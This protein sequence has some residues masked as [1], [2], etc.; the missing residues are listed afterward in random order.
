M[1]ANRYP[2]GKV[3]ADVHIPDVHML[4]SV[5]GSVHID[6]HVKSANPEVRNP[7]NTM[8]PSQVVRL[9]GLRAQLASWRAGAVAKIGS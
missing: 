4:S 6:P 7:A 5:G 3:L 9:H 2:G 8:L 1:N